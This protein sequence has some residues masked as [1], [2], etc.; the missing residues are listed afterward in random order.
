L[1]A[2]STSSRRPRSAAPRLLRC[3]VAVDIGGVEEVDT[4]IERPVDHA[5]RLLLVDRRDGG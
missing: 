3:A 2:R 1:V 5:M 4:G